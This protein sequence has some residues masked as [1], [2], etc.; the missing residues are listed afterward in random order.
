MQT[1]TWNN[2]Q[3]WRVCVVK[4]TRTPAELYQEQFAIEEGARKRNSR[5]PAP[6]TVRL[7]EL[8]SSSK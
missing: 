6:S 8:H 2:R 7:G 5:R 4:P 1:S 3:Q